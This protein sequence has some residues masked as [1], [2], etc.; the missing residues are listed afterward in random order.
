MLCVVVVRARSRALP[1]DTQ[2]PYYRRLI[3]RFEALAPTQVLDEDHAARG[4]WPASAV[5]PAGPGTLAVIGFELPPDVAVP[6]ALLQRASWSE[7]VDGS[8]DER[9]ALLQ[10]LAQTPP[11]RLLVVCHAASTPDRGTGRFLAGAGAVPTALLLVPPEHAGAAAPRWRAWLDQAGRA[12]LSVFTEADAAQR[13]S[14]GSH[15]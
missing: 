3:N 10:R 6:P 7:R 15:G 4:S 13:W 12:D 5:V 14:E 11:A 1:L 2:D 8:S 9:Q